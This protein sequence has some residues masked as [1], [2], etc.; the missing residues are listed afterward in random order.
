MKL[1][2]W[3]IVGAVVAGY[4]GFLIGGPNLAGGATLMGAL[5]ALLWADRYR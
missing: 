1:A 2:L 4:L 5:F 3:V